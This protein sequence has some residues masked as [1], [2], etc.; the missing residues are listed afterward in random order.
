MENNSAERLL[1][2][3]DRRGL[4]LRQV[5]ALLSAVD[6][7]ATAVATLREKSAAVQGFGALEFVL[8][9]TGAE[10]LLTQ[11]GAYRCAYGRAVAANIAEMAGNIARGWFVPDGVADHLMLPQAEFDDFRTDS[12]GLGALVGLVSHGVEA[13]RD[14]RINPFLAADGAVAK[15]QAAL[16]WRSGLTIEML[17]ANVTGMRRLVALSGMARAAAEASRGL[18]NSIDLEFGNAA[19]ALDLVT[20]PVEAAVEDPGQVQALHDLVLVTGLL[21]AMVGEQLPAALGLS[22]GWGR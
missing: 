9:G 6:A 14:T 2:W 15:P 17:G 3:P 20:L 10:T 13:M 8:H 7:T 18:D 22:V 19:R 5:Q 12:E 16:F 21:Q 4:G 1:F 11:A